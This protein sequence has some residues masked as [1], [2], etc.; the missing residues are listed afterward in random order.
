LSSPYWCM[1]PMRKSQPLYSRSGGYPPRHPPVTVSR[2]V[3]G[4]G[5]RAFAT[6]GRVCGGIGTPESPE[7]AY[8]GPTGDDEDGAEGEAPP[9]ELGVAEEEGR[10]A[11]ADERLGRDERRHDRDAPAVER[12]EEG[13]VREPERDPCRH[14]REH[15]P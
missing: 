7:C 8:E 3:P 14:A 5:R 9:D 13:D 12:L 2:P 4:T 6:W 11:H 15:S 1:P 10:E